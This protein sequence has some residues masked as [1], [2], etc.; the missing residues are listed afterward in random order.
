MGSFK[1]W[2]AAFEVQILICNNFKDFWMNVHTIQKE[3]NMIS[4]L[5]CLGQD[6]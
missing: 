1:C 4:L 3:L 5:N 6:A 2:K